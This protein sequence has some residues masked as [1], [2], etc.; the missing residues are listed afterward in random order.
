MTNFHLT[1]CKCEWMLHIFPFVCLWL[2]QMMRFSLSTHFKTCLLF[3]KCR[4]E[5]LLTV[6]AP[7]ICI[8]VINLGQRCF[9]CRRARELLRKKCYFPAFASRCRNIFASALCLGIFMS[10]GAQDSIAAA[11][12]HNY[13]YCGAATSGSQRAVDFKTQ[14]NEKHAHVVQRKCIAKLLL[15]LLRSASCILFVKINLDARPGI[16][17]PRGQFLFI[18]EISSPGDKK[19]TSEA[20]P[21]FVV[22]IY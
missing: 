21:N 19:R 2:Q 12:F 14:I 10:L 9:L 13:C 18:A 22:G 11:T 6:T 5:K 15:A 20:F 7:S 16:F 8:C 3:I 1:N 17:T 4:R